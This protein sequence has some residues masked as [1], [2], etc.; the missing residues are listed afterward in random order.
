MNFGN[1]SLAFIS[2]AFLFIA[3]MTNSNPAAYYA[4]AVFLG[5]VSLQNK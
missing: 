3:L 2:G 4:I 1:F 5:L